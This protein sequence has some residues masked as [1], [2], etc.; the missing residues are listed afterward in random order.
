MKD[1]KKD[2]YSDFIGKRIKYIR[3]TIFKDSQENFAERINEFIKKR[4]G[5]KFLKK[6]SFSQ[7][8]ISKLEGNSNATKEKLLIFLNFIH[9]KKRINS[10]WVILEDNNSQPMYTKKLV[11]DKNLIEI[12]KEIEENGD[13]IIKRISDIQI[14]INNTPFFK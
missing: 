1:Q 13:N 4:K 5:V 12:Y 10:A 2:M 11:V 3:V 7:H 8:I 6:N 14:I 9:E